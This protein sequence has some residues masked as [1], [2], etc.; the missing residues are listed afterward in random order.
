MAI[1]SGFMDHLWITETKARNFCN[2][3]I[4]R[5]PMEF[6]LHRFHCTVVVRSLLSKHAFKF[7]S[8]TTTPAYSA[9]ERSSAKER[10]FRKAFQA[11]NRLLQTKLKGT[12]PK[13]R[14]K[15]FSRFKIK[16]KNW[17]DDQCTCR[18]PRKFDFHI[19]FRV[20]LIAV[21]D[22][23]DWWCHGW[24]YCFYIIASGSLE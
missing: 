11:P 19:I 13:S 4:F 15:T 5:H 21:N 10:T 7:L 6:K 1:K 2:S 20:G 18:I 23:S 22:S 12:K 3:N 24:R 14:I 17:A 16:T 8:A 9:F